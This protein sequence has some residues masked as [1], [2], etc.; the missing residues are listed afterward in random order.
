MKTKNYK[1]Y[2]KRGVE[3]P[4]VIIYVLYTMILVIAGI[5]IGFTQLGGVNYTF[6]FLDLNEKINFI[7][8]NLLSNPACLAAESNYNDPPF[9]Q[10]HSQQT[11]YQV[12]AGIIDIDLAKL[13]NLDSECYQMLRV[14]TED[15]KK[16]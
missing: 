12:S 3:Q 2:S 1:C 13:Q 14:R 6:T 4:Q 16:L 11:Y 8:V 15:G 10:T 9:Q 5:Y 7:A